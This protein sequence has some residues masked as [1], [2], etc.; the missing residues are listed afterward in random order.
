MPKYKIAWL[1]GDGIGIEVLEAAKLVLDRLRLNADY[2]HGDIG[3]ELWCRE[4][5][6]FPQRTI[7]VLKTVDAALFG[8]ITS[9]PIKAAEA[10]LAPGGRADISS[11]GSIKV[12][13]TNSLTLSGSAILNIA[14]HSAVVQATPATRV[15]VLAAVQNFI[16]SAHDGLPTWTGPG[17]TSPRY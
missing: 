2:I 15:A 4:G 11:G 10:E 14:D 17:L 3:W 8:A 9:K 13:K 12:L 6:P 7:D 16:K 5:D 1:P